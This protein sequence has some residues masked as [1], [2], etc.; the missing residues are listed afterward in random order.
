MLE[1]NRYELEFM[2]MGTIDFEAVA[3]D[4]RQDIDRDDY[5]AQVDYAFSLQVDPE[6]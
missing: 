5:R 4:V 3:A 6:E 1:A 2:L